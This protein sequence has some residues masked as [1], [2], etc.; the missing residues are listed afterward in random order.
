ML[1]CR[2]TTPSAAPNP[3]VPKEFCQDNIQGHIHTTQR[4]T[5]S[6]SGTLN[7]NGKTDVLGHHMQV[8]GVV[9]GPPPACL[10]C[11][12]P[13]IWEVTPRF[14]PSANLSEKPECSP[15]CGPCQSHHQESCSSK[16]GATGS[17]PDKNLRRISLWSLERLDLG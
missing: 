8:C 7:T 17:S 3:I 15:H 6:P 4:V 1:H 12:D 5:I 13:H 14:L 16:P 11:T 10:H 9:Q 2:G